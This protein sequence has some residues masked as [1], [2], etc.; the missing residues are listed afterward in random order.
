[1]RFDNFCFISLLRYLINKSLFNSWW[2]LLHVLIRLRD[3][4]CIGS[5]LNYYFRNFRRHFRRFSICC[6][7]IDLSQCWPKL[8]SIDQ[9]W[10]YFVKLHSSFRHELRFSNL[11][12]ALIRL[13]FRSLLLLLL[14]GIRHLCLSKIIDCRGADIHKFL[15]IVMHHYSR[16]IKQTFIYY[17]DFS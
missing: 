14:S 2:G 9:F 15:W 13:S 4:C 6:L 1:M 12:P 5:R 10:C 3:Q 7:G 11:W 16:W 17:T 8:L